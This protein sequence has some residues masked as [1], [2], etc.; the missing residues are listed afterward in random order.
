MKRVCEAEILD[1]DGGSP[2]EIASALES[3][4]RIN[5][6]FGGN[7][8][9]TRLLRRAAAHI[10]TQRKLHLLEVASGQADV[11]QAAV[12]QL[13]W[14]HRCSI[15]LLDRSAQHLPSAASWPPDLPAPERITGDA[16]AIPLADQSVDI[17]ACCLFLHHLDEQQAR[18]FLKEALRVARVAVIVNDLERNRLHYLL[19]RLA[20][21][22]DP[23]RIS[24]HDGPVSVRQAYTAGELRSLLRQ[25]GQRFEL[26]RGFLFR[27]GAVLWKDPAPHAA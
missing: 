12:R 6:R 5:L 10:E 25:T 1:Q 2:S 27:L 20:A 23:S 9:H 22:M 7:R 24:R 13:N 26:P 21:L 19:A 16:L 8:M 18:V 17:V 3:I 4:R 11:L 15:T 14:Q